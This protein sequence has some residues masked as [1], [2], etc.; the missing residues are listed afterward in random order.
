MAVTHSVSKHVR[1][2]EPTMKIWMKIDPC[3]QKR[4][5]SPMT[6]D[7]GNMRFMWIFS[8]FIW[9][10]LRFMY[11]CVHIL[12]IKYGMPYS[13]LRSCLWFITQLPIWGC[14]EYSSIGVTSGDGKRSSGLWSA[15]YLESAENL[16]IFRGRY[17]VGTLTNNAN[18]IIQYYSALSP[19]HW[20]QNTW[21]WMTLNRHFALNSVLY[22]YVWTS[23]AWLSKLGYS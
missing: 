8:R 22:L 15:E 11:A 4:K 12:I 21:L 3:C 16:R 17:I 5:C 19:F 9:I 10:F 20:L 7:S 23:E 18:I 1:L 2:S 14:R 6:L 13:I